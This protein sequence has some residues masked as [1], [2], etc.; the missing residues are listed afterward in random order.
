[1]FRLAFST[2]AFKKN[3]LEEAIDAIA[4]AGFAGVELMADVPHAYPPALD[5]AARMAIKR[6]I[7]SLG[8]IVSNI[9]AFTLFASG[10]TYHPT[11]IEHDEHHRDLRVE[12]TRQ[13]IELARDMQCGTVSIQPGGPLIGT[14]LNQK[15]A[16]KRFSESLA[17]I[18]PLAKKLDVILAIEPEPGLLIQTAGEYLQFKN[19]YFRDDSSV[20][21]NCDVGH[22]FCVEED[23]AEVI[24]SMPGEIAH[25]HLEDIAANRVHQHLAP[26]KGSIDFRSIFAALRD[27]DYHGWVTVELYPYEST[28]AEVAKNSM[29]YLRPIVEAS[30]S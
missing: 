9:N 13:C 7:D 10:D 16:A 18:V 11:W 4:A 29:R 19:A 6:R 30:Y 23:P 8:L 20:H 17:R 14:A 25:V 1:M 21:M 2:N 12:H 27:I 28:A 15:T 3:S 5:S 24:R 26:G 22:L